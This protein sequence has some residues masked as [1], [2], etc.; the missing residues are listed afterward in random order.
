[1]KYGFKDLFGL[2]GKTALVTG[3]A[4]IIGKELCRGLAEFGANVAVVDIVS[5]AADSLAKSLRADY[6]VKT[7]GLACDV[8]SPASVRGMVD[9]V[10][11]EF[12][13]IDILLNNAASKSDD[14]DKF[15]AP[16]ETYSLEEWNKVM[17]VN[18]DGMMLVA[19][20]VGGEMVKAGRGG[21]IV[22]TSSI[23]GMMAPDHGIYEG[24][25]YLGKQINTPA[26][27]AA[28]KAG[29]VGLTRYLATYWAKENIRVNCLVPGGVESGQNEEFKRRYSGRIPLGRMARAQE[30]V[31]PTLYLVS[32]AS[33]YVTGQCVM[34]DGGLSAW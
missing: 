27:Y 14:L 3:G 8:S 26:V 19:Q 25:F 11:S 29:V 23:Y 21:A 22:Q 12:G 24:S 33:S 6:D 17:A 28:S 5:E 32:N 18:L 4:G 1:M 9:R 34:V 20:A 16:F 7:L 13:H 31:G 10:V 30:M 2:Q 15:F